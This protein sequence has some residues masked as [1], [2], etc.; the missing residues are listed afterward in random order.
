MP[1]RLVYVVNRRTVV[2]QTTDEV[3][4]LRENL[5]KLEDR[6]DHIRHLAI[7]TL[8]GQ[9]ADN[10]EWLAD[11]SWPAVICGTVDMIGSRLLFSGYGIGFKTKPMHAGFLGQDVLLVHDEA[12]LEPAF[13]NLLTEIV[14]E[15]RRCKEFGQFL[16]ME[17][18]A[19]SRGNGSGQD[20][21][22]P[23]GLTDAE[24]SPPDVV[25]DPPP[26]LFIMCGSGKKRRRQFVFM[27]S[28]MKRK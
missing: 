12:H 11:P 9:F 22:P 19:T 25:P 27:K 20:D 7:S 2:D 14:N 18:S 5:L 13:Q 1:R 16:L 17:L 23:F 15:Q 6:P 10:H 8:R 24:K 3:Q 28:T 26:N 4:K 21:E